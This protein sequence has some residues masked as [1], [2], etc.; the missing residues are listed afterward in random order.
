MPIN[1]S[2]MLGAMVGGFF[3][4]VAATPQSTV[5]TLVLPS[6][7]P[8]SIARQFRPEGTLSPVKVMVRIHI[9]VNMSVAIS[10]IRGTDN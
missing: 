9:A 6:Y 10:A 1:V 5:T 7:Q 3:G 8:P 4:A 2:K